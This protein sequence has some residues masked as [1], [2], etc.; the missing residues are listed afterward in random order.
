MK[1]T[2]TFRLETNLAAGEKIPTD[3]YGNMFG[4]NEKNLSP[5]L[6]WSSVPSGTK[7]LAVTLFDKDAPTESGFWH[8]VLY[9]IPADVTKIDLG[10]LSSGQIPKGS[11]ESITDA[12]KP[13]YLG[14]C[15][16]P[17]REHNYIYTVHAL[18][19]EK[20]ELP[21]AST[22]AF[23]SF[24]LWANSLGKASFSVKAGDKN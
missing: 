12:G 21:S 16:P 11:I 5:R 6:E 14:P 2:Q 9:N 3:Y 1:E 13:G 24:N 10:Q 22:P 18:K 23:V 20:L 4:Y 15:P 8:Y 17:G 7:S 19:L